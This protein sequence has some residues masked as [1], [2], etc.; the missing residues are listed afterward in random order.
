M[1]KTL[2]QILGWVFLTGLVKSIKTGIPDVL[3]PEFYSITKDTLADQGRYTQ[4]TGTRKV[5]RRV[6]YGAPA[7]NR[8]LRDVASYDVKLIHTFEMIQL[9]VAQYQSLRGYTNYN[10]QDFGQ[11][12]VERQAVEFRAYFDNLEKATLYSVLANMQI[13][14]DGNGNLLP[15]SAGS[16]VTVNYNPDA[17]HQNQLNGII[18]SSWTSPGTDIPLHIRL[19]QKQ[20]AKDTGYV[21]ENCFYGVNIPSYLAINQYAQPFLARSPAMRE[22]FLDTGE[23]PQ[24]LFGIKNWHPVYT[25]FFDQGGPG[26]ALSLQEFFN[27]D[28]AV[29]TPKIDSIWYDF[30]RGTY[31]V[32]T[33]FQPQTQL[34]GTVN[35][36]EIVQGM[37]G[38][39]VPIANP[40]T[41][42][43]FFGHT[44]LPVVKFPDAIFQAIV[45]P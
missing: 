22:K 24:G 13:Y 4:V 29:F 9:N 2:E 42:Q 30:M 14:F 1:A 33:T 25:A 15:T 45:T 17:N 34:Q 3:P 6:E 18:S 40:M 41:A 20:S 26:S 21:L 7:M 38:Y 10:V 37:F 8:N 16:I 36:F 43:M 31:P 23:I 19:I 44:F 5:S 39:G 28:A 32:P 11:Q 12:E 27:V 35:S